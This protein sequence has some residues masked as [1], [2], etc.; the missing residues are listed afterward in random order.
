VGWRGVISH[1]LLSRYASMNV[2]ATCGTMLFP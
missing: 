1:S 2:A